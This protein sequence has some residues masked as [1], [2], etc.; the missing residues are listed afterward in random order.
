MR[1]WL[2]EAFGLDHGAAAVLVELFEAQTQWSD[3]PRTS[4][5]LVEESLSPEGD[6]WIYVFHAPLHA[7]PAKC[8]VVRLQPGWAVAGAETW[9]CAWPTWGGQFVYP[10][11][12]RPN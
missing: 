1:D 8:S 12:A 7:P 3:I 2:I 4:E 9:G 11:M 5:I 10:T 6:G